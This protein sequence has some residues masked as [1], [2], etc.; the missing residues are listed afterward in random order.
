[1]KE[2]TKSAETETNESI[3]QEEEVI[4]NIYIDKKV[5]IVFL[6]YAPGTN[7]DEVV[8]PALKIRGFEKISIGEFLKTHGVNNKDYGES[9]KKSLE[10]KIPVNGETIVHLI[11]DYIEG[12]M[13]R[14]T[15][16]LICGFPKTEEN[17]NSWKSIIGSEYTVNALIYISYTRKEYEHEIR[18]RESEE[19]KKFEFAE[20]TN[21]FNYFIKNTNL[22]FDDFG[23][24]KMIK[25]S[26][27][28]ADDLIRDHIVKHP[29]FQKNFLKLD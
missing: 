14:C 18:L 15:R 8:F 13:K 29:I 26:A 24:K 1:M 11:K 21:R 16:Y 22:V 2:I 12:N 10:E 23:E 5:H 27:K 7:K 3:N 28:L 20:V 4:N 9:I 17:S 25:I 19:G 6:V